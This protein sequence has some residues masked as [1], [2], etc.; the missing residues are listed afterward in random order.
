M[1]AIKRG[2]KRSF[3]N[4]KPPMQDTLCPA[5]FKLQINETAKVLQIVALN[6][7][8]NHSLDLESLTSLRQQIL[9]QSQETSDFYPESDQTDIVCTIFRDSSTDI[10]QYLFMLTWAPNWSDFSIIQ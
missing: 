8:H 3:R 10:N 7:K 6:K 9:Q 2:C 1:H 5:Y 4:H